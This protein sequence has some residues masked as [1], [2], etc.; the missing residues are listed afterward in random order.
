MLKSMRARLFLILIVTTSVV[1]LSAIA[2]IFTSTQAQVERVL[3][4]RLMEAA[5]M[6]SSL[7][8][9]EDV[10]AARAANL[11]SRR[12]TRPSSYERQLSC[13]IWSF[14]GNLLSKSDTAPVAE[15]TTYRDGFSET[16]INGE[17]WRVYAAENKHL[18]IRVLVGD[19]RRIRAELVGDVVKG[20]ALP[21]LLIMPVL[22]AL[23]WVSVKRGFAPLNR[24]AAGLG[25]RPASD[26][27]PLSTDNCGTEIRPVIAALNGLFV[28]VA[29]TRE[30]ERN[31]TTF[32]A[33]E[34][35][36]PLA[37]LKTQAQVALASE[38][39]QV[40]QRALSQIVDAVNRTGRLVRQLLDLAA[41][42]ARESGA[43]MGAVN[44]G[45]ALALLKNEFFSHNEGCPQIVIANALREVDLPIKSD[46]FSIAARNLLENALAYSPPRGLVTCSL[47]LTQ[48]EIAVVIEDSGPG[49][50]A[51][52]IG[53]VKERFFRG[54]NKALVG[55]GLGLS[56]AEIALQHAGAT[57]ELSNRQL[58]GLSATIKIGRVEAPVSEAADL[59]K[60]AFFQSVPI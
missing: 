46:L 21:A 19:T 5:N 29:D 1:W 39:S 17:T 14:A 38:N 27:S 3:D 53:H 16:V 52:E 24:I 22:A 47:R 13:Q 55:S 33:H 40:R 41:V 36:T 6:V 32:A 37:G 11:A 58:G 59:V 8:I 51:D 54:R 18:G 45:E 43:E 60:S 57:L 25:S 31:F 28:R 34:L 10:S 4:A 15:L 35:R 9:E 30:R 26:L 2:W 7:L 20:L 44:P 12:P 48:D 42:E 56:I 23:I 49:I 50:P